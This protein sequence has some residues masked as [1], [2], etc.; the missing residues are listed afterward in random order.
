MGE[1]RHGRPSGRGR[2]GRRRRRSRSRAREIAVARV[3]GTLYA[4]S[5]ICTHRAATS[6]AAASSRA[7]SI[8][9]RV[10]RQHVRRS[11]PVRCWTGPRPSRSRCT[12][13]REVDGQIQIEAVGAVRPRRPSSSSAPS[14]AGGDGGGDPPRGRVR[15]PARPARRRAAS[16]RTNA[17][18]CRSGTCAAR[19]PRD[20]LFVRP[21]EWWRGARRRD[22]A[23]LPRAAR[24]IR[25]ARRVTLAD[26]ETDRVRPGAGRDGRAQPRASTFRAPTWRASS[27]CGRSADADRIRAAAAAATATPSSSGWGSSAPRWPR[28]SASSGSRSRS[29]RC[30]RPPCTGSLGPRLGRVL[31]AIHRDHGVTMRFG[32]TVERF[33]GDGRV[34][35]VVTRAGAEHRRAISSSSASGTEP[36]AE[37]L[38]ALRIAADG[39]IRVGRRRC[40]TEFPG[41]FAAGDV[42]SHDHPVFGRGARGALRQRDQD[43]GARGARDARLAGRVRRPAL[44]L[45]RPVRRTRSR[46][47]GV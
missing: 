24:S 15:R 4:F 22:A 3:D 39:G 8:D 35:R 38:G 11:R 1:L 44:V 28:R 21:A 42:A 19:S 34:E 46:W 10:P 32:D 36:N 13:S 41:V 16:S 17:R 33:E 37:V 9:V 6:R 12:R 26:G 25:R 14:L 31:E 27:S 2:G 20:E 43:G 29:S 47:A 40:E 23:R 30:S 5:D 7:P 45:V 18:A